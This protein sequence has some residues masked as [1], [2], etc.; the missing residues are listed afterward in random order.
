MFFTSVWNN[1]Y[2]ISVTVL[3]KVLWSRLLGPVIQLTYVVE[4]DVVVALTSD[5][6]DASLS[7]VERKWPSPER[8]KSMSLQ[9]HLV[10]G[11]GFN[12]ALLTGNVVEHH[13]HHEE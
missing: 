9:H 1:G 2:V 3:D 5:V 7:A 12:P 4:H 8:L 10:H 13:R 11:I 6:R